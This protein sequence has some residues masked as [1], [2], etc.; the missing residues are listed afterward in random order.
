MY[1]GRILLYNIFV[2]HISGIRLSG[3]PAGRAVLQY[4]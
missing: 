3:Y 4:A 1:A 2:Q